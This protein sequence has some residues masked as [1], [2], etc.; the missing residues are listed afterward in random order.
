MPSGCGSESQAPDV[1][2]LTFGSLRPPLTFIA[3]S[4]FRGRF[5][6]SSTGYP[7]LDF[8]LPLRSTFWTGN[9]WIPSGCQG[10]PAPVSRL[11]ATTSARLSFHRSFHR[12]LIWRVVGNTPTSNGRGLLNFPPGVIFRYAP[13]L[14]VICLGRCVRRR[15]FLFVPDVLFRGRILFVSIA[16]L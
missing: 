13:F 7:V 5:R 9:R 8:R 6:K 4:S 15:F 3:F 16:F 1:R 12:S 10:K 2:C 11:P 14:F